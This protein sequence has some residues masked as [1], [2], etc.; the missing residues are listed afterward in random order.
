MAFPFQLC[1][2]RKGVNFRSN[3]EPLAEARFLYAPNS[4][5][6]A[7]G[8]RLGRAPD[9]THEWIDWGTISWGA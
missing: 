6:R 9:S 3:M 1:L 8:F 7:A 4:G 2:S 5:I